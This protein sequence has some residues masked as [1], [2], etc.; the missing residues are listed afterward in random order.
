[1][2]ADFGHVAEQG[3]LGALAV[4][5]RLFAAAQQD[6][7]LDAEAGELAHAMLGRLGLQLARGRDP[8]HQGGVDADRVVAAEVVA[9][10]ADRLDERQAFDVADRAADLADDEIDVVDVG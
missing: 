6:V 10:L 5:Q 4:G 7:G 3:D 8:R 9:Q 1:M 2:T